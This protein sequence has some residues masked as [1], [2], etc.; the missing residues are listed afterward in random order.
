MRSQTFTPE[1]LD[2]LDRINSL[3]A[4]GSKPAELSALDNMWHSKLVANSDNET[5][6]ETIDMLKAR[7]QRYEEA[8]IRYSGALPASARHHR[9]ITRALRNGE[10]DIAAK[11]LEDN[12]LAGI[13][14]LVPW[15]ESQSQTH[16]GG[17]TT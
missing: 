14:F 9:A 16:A 1:I 10:L 3:F 4:K 5:L 13:R 2:E 11:N 12:W 8:Y 6:H 15:L 17:A 7:V